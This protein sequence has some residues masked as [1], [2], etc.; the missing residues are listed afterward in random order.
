MATIAGVRDLKRVLSTYRADDPSSMGVVIPELRTLLDCDASLGY[1]MVPIGDR[2]RVDFLEVHGLDVPPGVWVSVVEEGSP[3]HGSFD[4]LRPHASQRN[5]VVLLGELGDISH[6]RSYSV[7]WTRYGMTSLDQIRVLVC[8]G[9]TMLGFVGG[10]R[11]ARRPF[12]ERERRRLGALVP[13]LRRRLSLERAVRAVR[14]QGAALD[15]LLEAIDAPAFFVS[16]WNTVRATNAAGRLLLDRDRAEVVRA[17]RESAAG[18]VPGV[19]STIV[20]SRGAPEH[21]LVVL[22]A[23]FADPAPRVARAAVRWGLTRRQGEVLREIAHGRPNK[24]IAAAL[25]CAEGTIE[26]HVSAILERAQAESRAELVARV[27]SGE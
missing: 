27:W 1:G 9:P 25:G 13:A 18:T 7:V 19:G 22:E 11:D 10:Y 24:T 21:R 12:T 20:A 2:A 5:R 16:K 17:I 6:T 23:A 8:D 14:R 26:L 4:S 3:T 15:V